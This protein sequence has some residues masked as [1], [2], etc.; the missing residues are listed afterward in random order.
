MELCI[1]WN[2]LYTEWDK[3]PLHYISLIVHIDHCVHSQNIIISFFDQRSKWFWPHESK[4]QYLTQLSKLLN[5]ILPRMMA[6]V[7]TKKRGPLLSLQI[8]LLIFL[9]PIINNALLNIKPIRQKY[10]LLVLMLNCF[11]C[12]PSWY[13]AGKRLL[14]CPKL[15][16]CKELRK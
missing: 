11:Y 6:P 15:F 16:F 2:K 8:S 1:Y 12:K 13:I 10:F 4:T 9:T 7:M 3:C 5:I 14:V